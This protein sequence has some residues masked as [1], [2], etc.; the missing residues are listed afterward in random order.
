V[1]TKI[2]LLCASL[3]AA[4]IV[5]PGLQAATEVMDQVVAIVDDD[6]IMASELRERT[7]SLAET[8][9]SRDIELP[10]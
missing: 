5:A 4:I 7:D 2:L 8:L 6:V 10:P 1:N 3:A 9:K